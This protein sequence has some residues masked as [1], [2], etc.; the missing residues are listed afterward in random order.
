MALTKGKII[1]F[2]VLI[3]RASLVADVLKSHGFDC[4]VESRLD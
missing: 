2:N 4:Y 3:Q 1:G